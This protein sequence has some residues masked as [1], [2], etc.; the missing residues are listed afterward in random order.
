MVHRVDGAMLKDEFNI[1]PEF[2]TETNFFA[3]LIKL[4]L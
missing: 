4:P 3:T 2:V 1:K